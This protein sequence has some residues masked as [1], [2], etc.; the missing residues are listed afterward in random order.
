[1]YI[2]IKNLKNRKKYKLYYTSNYV[3]VI[4]TSI[5]NMMIYHFSIF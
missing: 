5:L 1:M 4:K 2:Y 3:F